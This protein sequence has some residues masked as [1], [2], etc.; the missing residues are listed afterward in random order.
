M[1]SG[2]Y[3]QA[4]H[5][6]FDGEGY[7]CLGVAC[8]VVGGFT[9]TANESSGLLLSGQSE[10]VMNKLKFYGS[11]GQGE[12]GLSKSLAGYNDKGKSFKEIAA[13]I[14]ANP[15]DWFKSE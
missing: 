1:E 6:L 8:E 11:L 5:V 7:C 2:E 12:L 3:K 4:T 15:E 14:R 13:M 10:E 9:P